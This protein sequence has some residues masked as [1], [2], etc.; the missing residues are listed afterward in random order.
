MSFFINFQTRNVLTM[1]SLD[2]ST[3]GYNVQF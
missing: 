1:S 3:N 2:F